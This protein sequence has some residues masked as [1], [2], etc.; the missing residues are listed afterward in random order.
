M[1]LPGFRCLLALVRP[2][3]EL[4]FASFPSRPARLTALVPHKPCWLKRPKRE[5]A[6]RQGVDAEGHVA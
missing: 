1:S 5:N 4:V 3:Q 2:Y 6:V